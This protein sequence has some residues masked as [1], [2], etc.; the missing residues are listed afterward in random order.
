MRALSKRDVR[1]HLGR[2]P[3]RFDA[4]CLAVHVSSSQRTEAEVPEARAD[5]RAGYAWHEPAHPTEALDAFRGDGDFLNR[6]N[7]RIEED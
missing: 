6:R 5:E 2:S 1:E 4:F 3:D 7:R